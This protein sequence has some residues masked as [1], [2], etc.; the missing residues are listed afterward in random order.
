MAI[1]D[2]G[3]LTVTCDDC[4]ETVEADTTQYAG[5]G[6]SFGVED[7]TLKD[8][9]WFVEHDQHYCPECAKKLGFDEGE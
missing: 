7:Q 2:P 9:G 1:E 5:G 3:T 4:G 6:V 8:L